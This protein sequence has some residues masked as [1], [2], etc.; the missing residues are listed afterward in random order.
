MS[1]VAHIAKHAAVRLGAVLAAVVALIHG[2][3]A[4]MAKDLV[5]DIRRQVGSPI[6]SARHSS[7]IG[8]GW[9]RFAD[10]WHW[11]EAPKVLGLALVLLLL[12]PAHGEVEVR[13]REG[14]L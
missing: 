7:A 6:Y 4:D 14:S 1:Q 3:R 8:I 5:H 11:E 10:T 13:F 9:I 2:V 12:E